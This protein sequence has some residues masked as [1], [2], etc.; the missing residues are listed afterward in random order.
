MGGDE[1]ERGGCEFLEFVML[2][3]G[4]YSNEQAVIELTFALIKS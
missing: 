3:H 1:D 4:Y 2:E